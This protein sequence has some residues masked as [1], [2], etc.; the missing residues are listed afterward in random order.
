VLRVDHSLE[1]SKQSQHAKEERLDRRQTTRKA[2]TDKRTKGQ[3]EKK[4]KE[5]QERVQRESQKAKASD[6]VD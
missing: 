5:K 3:K 2:A 6:Y 4:A 1:L